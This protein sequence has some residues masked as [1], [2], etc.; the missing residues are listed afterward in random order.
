MLT[1][2]P[3]SGFYNS[4][5]DQELDYE[6]ERMFADRATGCQTNDALLHHAL[7]VVDWGFV[8]HAYAKEYA[9]QFAWKFKVQMTFES[10]QSPR[11]YNFTTDRIFC[12]IPVRE[13]HRIIGMVGLD[14]ISELARERFTSCSGFYSPDIEDWGQIST[15]DHNQV[16][17]VMEA[18]AAGE[19]FDGGQEFDLMEDPR[20]NGRL[21]EWLSHSEKMVRLLNIHDYLQ[22]RRERA[23][24]WHARP[25]LWD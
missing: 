8:H 5:H 4:L 23:A 18:L 15:W 25:H 3:F 11:E 7:D 9:E 19:D 22:D 10:L 16:G 2:I 6:L 24:K 12:E 1:T 20:G 17:T 13:V 14:A 21:E